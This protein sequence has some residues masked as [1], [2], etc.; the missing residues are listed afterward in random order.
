MKFDGRAGCISEKSWMSRITFPCFS[1][2]EF[3]PAEQFSKNLGASL[4]IFQKQDPSNRFLMVR[5]EMGPKDE[6]FG[7]FQEQHLSSV[8]QGFCSEGRERAVV[9]HIP[10][11]GE[12]QARV[13][14]RPTKPRLMGQELH[15]D[16]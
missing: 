1:L 14:S 13:R 3:F 10:L 8:A 12:V 2:N 16:C 7:Q 4:D 15:S 9:N 6:R 5:L 11:L